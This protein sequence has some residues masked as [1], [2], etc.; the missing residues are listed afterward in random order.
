VEKI[1]DYKLQIAAIRES[2]AYLNL[3][4]STIF[5]LTTLAKMLADF[6]LN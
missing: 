1:A 5:V 3:A 6:E 2:V 4:N